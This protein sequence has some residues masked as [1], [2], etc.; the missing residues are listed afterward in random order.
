MLQSRRVCAR[1]NFTSS[2]FVL[3]CACFL[4]AC[5]HNDINLGARYKKVA[6]QDPSDDP[7]EVYSM[8]KDVQSRDSRAQDPNLVMVAAL[9]GGGVRAANFSLGTFLALEDTQFGNTDLLRQIDYLSTVS[10]GGFAAGAYVSALLTMPCDQR[11]S[12]KFSDYLKS[13]RDVLKDLRS[14]FL[15][16]ETALKVANPALLV[17]HKDRGDVIQELLADRFFTHTRDVIDCAD[18]TSASKEVKLGHIFVPSSG[19]YDSVPTTPYLI[20][21]ATN[22]SNGDI[23]SFTP[24]HIEALGV[25]CFT[26]KMQ[27]QPIDKGY[28]YEMPLAAGIRSSANFPVGLATATY[29]I[30]AK[31]HKGSI[32]NYEYCKRA[33]T[34]GPW[35]H[36]QLTD[37]GEAD[38]LGIN[39]AL[40]IL[41]HEYITKG[42]K[43]SEDTIYF[44]LIV[45]AF[46][47]QV[48]P[49]SSKEASGGP[50]S[51]LL[52]ATDIPLA[53]FRK[54]T[55]AAVS[56]LDGRSFSLLDAISERHDLNVAYVH[57]DHLA[58]K[59]SSTGTVLPTLLG[60]SIDTQRDL[61][62][63]GAY[64]TFYV[65]GV[66]DAEDRAKAL[67]SDLFNVSEY[68]E[69]FPRSLSIQSNP[70]VQFSKFRKRGIREKH[71]SNSITA[72]AV[73][74]DAAVAMESQ[75][76]RLLMRERIAEDDLHLQ[77]FKTAKYDQ[78]VGATPETFVP[79][80]KMFDPILREIGDGVNRHKSFAETIESD[81]DE[82]TEDQL[83]DV[84]Q[85]VSDYKDGLDA[86]RNTVADYL[87]VEGVIK[88]FAVLEAQANKLF[89][90]NF[91]IEKTY[92][93]LGIAPTLSLPGFWDAYIGDPNFV[94]AVVE[95]KDNYQDEYGE[96]LEDSNLHLEKKLRYE[97]VVEKET[98][99]LEQ[100][101][102][103]F[104]ENIES[105]PEP[106]LFSSLKET[107]SDISV[108]LASL[109]VP[110]TSPDKFEVECRS[111]A[112]GIELLRTAENQLAMSRYVDAF[113]TADGRAN[114]EKFPVCIS[115]ESI[116]GNLRGVT[117]NLFDSNEVAKSKLIEQERNWPD[118]FRR[119][120]IS[121]LEIANGNPEYES[122]C[123]RETSKVETIRL[124]D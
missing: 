89:E 75:V 29:D 107:Y 32:L 41:N 63:A 9:S 49:A 54:L 100:A 15:N 81:A 122:V 78:I 48:D 96:Y 92:I 123:V 99:R 112:K 31:Q 27:K 114:L 42:S 5:A 87:T 26:H 115:D 76:K 97:E 55:S 108:S 117:I 64:Q 73:A 52:K 71:V 20:A 68:L 85:L 103:E 53:S 35:S 67:V 3:A 51:E 121:Y 84:Q 37:G 93:E 104:A 44:L 98:K 58:E 10:G 62:A 70:I 90:L 80:R 56:D 14:G 22:H 118:I 94:D 57:M 79:N 109:R 12:F 30:S 47:G 116:C 65:L 106:T 95:A 34:G 16:L 4:A 39:S 124:P 2:G 86:I 11:W 102:Y 8:Y 33:R 25:T 77:L 50:L 6:T 113:A 82:L 101:F 13:N 23:V 1:H 18:V 74:R 17:S 72:L 110:T 38:N 21:N 43:G 105:E 119:E 28:F 88:D 59:Y 36:L 19:G 61:I 45:D 46:N 40:R 60:V 111:I 69:P 91:F 24:H 66:P 83:E 7:V 120:A